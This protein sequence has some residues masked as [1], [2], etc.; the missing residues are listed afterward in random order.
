MEIG[1]LE[2]VV[3]GFDDHQFASEVL[4][5]LNAI[6]EHGLIR[7]VDLVFV[8]KKTAG[9][10]SLQEVSELNEEEV[11]AYE[12]FAEDLMGLLTAQDVEHLT[13]EVPCDTSAVIVLLEHNWTLWLA[14]AVR[15]GGGVLFTGGMVSPEVLEKVSAELTTAKEEN[16]A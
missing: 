5:E 10:V 15:R 12:G 11:S 6:Q 16:H 8:S 2:Y 14:Q 3:I 7:I 4:P 9:T 1:P 13:R